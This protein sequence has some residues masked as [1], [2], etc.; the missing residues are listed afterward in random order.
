AI[1]AW[2]RQHVRHSGTPVL[3]VPLDAWPPHYPSVAQSKFLLRAGI[4]R[5]MMG[6]LTR[7]GTVEGFGGNIGRLAL[8]DLQSHF[9][10]DLAGTATAHL[11]K[12]LYDAPGRD[13]A[14]HADE[15]GHRQ[16]WFAARDIAFE[17][18]VD[19]DEVAGMM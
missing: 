6:T 7:I 1:E 17:D 16:M 4:T 18:P 10:D 11:T 2:Q 12:G 5:P 3:E 9:A 13:E 15:G 8:H 14:G 19:R